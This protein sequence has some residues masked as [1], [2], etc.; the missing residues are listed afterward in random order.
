MSHSKHDIGVIK[1][2]GYRYPV[3]GES[4]MEWIVEEPYEETGGPTMRVP[5]KDAE[6]IVMYK[7]QEEKS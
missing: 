2:N 5:K 6:I 4:L 1:Y 3:V 7:K